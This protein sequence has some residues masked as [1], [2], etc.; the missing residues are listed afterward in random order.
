MMEFAPS[1]SPLPRAVLDTSV[2]MSGDRHWLWVAALQ[3]LFEG[4]W[5]AFI[6]AELV[7][8]RYRRTLQQSLQ[9][10]PIEEFLRNKDYDRRIGALVHELSK[11]LDLADYQAVTLSNVLSDP[12]D[13]YVLTTALAGRAAYIVSYNIKDFPTNNAVMGV[14]YLT[15]PEFEETLAAVHPTVDVRA[16]GDNPGQRLP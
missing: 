13:E 12:D 15:P 11:V 5:S 9:R 14:R 8:V 2:L 4:V 7:R 3:G 16:L 10:M 1:S 6:V